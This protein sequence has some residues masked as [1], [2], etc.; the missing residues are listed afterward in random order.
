MSCERYTAGPR[1]M[2]PRQRRN[3]ERVHV[4]R[5]LAERADDEPAHGPELAQ[6]ASEEDG[7][8]A[9][10]TWH[11]AAGGVDV[12]RVPLVLA[13]DRASSHRL[14]HQISRPFLGPLLHRFALRDKWRVYI[15]SLA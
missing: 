15:S 5:R 13:G 2:A 11:A 4:R 8:V 9:G 12:A 10:A 14:M 6:Q 1:A 3:E 7:A